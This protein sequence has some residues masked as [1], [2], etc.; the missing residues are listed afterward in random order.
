MQNLFIDICDLLI[1]AIGNRNISGIQRVE[2]SLLHYMVQSDIRF[3]LVNAFGF[4]SPKLDSIIRKWAH[5]PDDLLRE[6]NREC[7][8]LPLRKIVYRIKNLCA[9]TVSG[10]LPWP[11]TDLSQMQA[12]DTLFV[13]GAY[14]LD[15]YIMRFYAAAATKGVKLVVLIHDVLPITHPHL[16]IAGSDRFF[17]PILKLP[18]HVI[19]GSQATKNALPQAVEKIAGAAMPVSIEVVHF[20]QEFPGVPRNQPPGKPNERLKNIVRSR[21]FVLYVSTVEVR[22][23]HRPL[24]EVWNKLGVERGS[25][26]PL[27]VIA[28]KKGWEAEETIGLL[29][30]ANAREQQAPGTEPVLFIEGPSDSELQWL[31]AA[32]DFTVFSSLAE[33]WGLPVGESLWFGKTCAASSATSIPEVGGDLCIY[34]DPLQPEEIEAA[35]KTLLDPALRGSQEANIRSA[36]LRSWHDAARD[37]AAAVLTHVS[38][39]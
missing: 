16:M 10:L 14:W 38:R 31:Y 12:G 18:I 1:Y 5:S 35:V 11:R 22:K 27:L 32:C 30:A 23:N 21:A 36:R 20:A 9:R 7:T 34:F 2:T 17:S 8:N 13:P 3:R 29:D 15:L 19:T 28:G 25:A 6:L 4:D 39:P 26:L 33:G 24:I 37:L